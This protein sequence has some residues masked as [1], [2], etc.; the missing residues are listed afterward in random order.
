MRKQYILFLF[1]IGGNTIWP[2]WAL[3]QTNELH[4]NVYMFSK[5]IILNVI[6]K[7]IRHKTEKMYGINNI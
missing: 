6:L 4:I 7:K 3:I 5:H 2:N 1:I